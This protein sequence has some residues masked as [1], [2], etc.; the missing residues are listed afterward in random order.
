MNRAVSL[1]FDAKIRLGMSFL[2]AIRRNSSRHV[3]EFERA[4]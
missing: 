2:M 1:S 4:A 3:P